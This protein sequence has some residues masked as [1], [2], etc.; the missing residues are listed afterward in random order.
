MDYFE[1]EIIE[2]IAVE[3]VNLVKITLIEAKL[4]WERLQ[5]V[6]LPGHKKII[7]DISKCMIIFHIFEFKD[8]G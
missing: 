6:V 5:N 1:N 3:K 8:C 2:D 4:F 7:V